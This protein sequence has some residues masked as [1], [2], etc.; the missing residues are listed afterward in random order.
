MTSHIAMLP[1]KGVAVYVLNNQWSRAPEAVTSGVLNAFL[2][3][4]PEDWTAAFSTSEG[5]RA[6]EASKEVEE[7]FAARDADST[8]SLPVE[9]YEGTYRDPWY[10]DVF[11]EANEDGLAMR[12]SRSVKLTGPLEH[13]Q[14]DT[15]IARWLDRSLFADA[16]VTF[17]LGADGRV[18]KITMKAV[19]PDTDFSY[20]FHDLDLRR[21]EED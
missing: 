7:A 20:D 3:D 9:S 11:V 5:E 15:F 13:F 4:A 16:Y 2:S 17:I 14:Y 21:V 6:A 19:S 18:E 8:P 12:F 10:G 1:E